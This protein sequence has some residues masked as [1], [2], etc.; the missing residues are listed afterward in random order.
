MQS[1][2]GGLVGCMQ[3]EHYCCKMCWSPKH[4]FCISI[5]FVVDL[6]IAYGNS[7]CFLYAAVLHR[8][9]AS[10]GGNFALFLST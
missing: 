3:V 10:D 5:L 9:I 7:I 6:L 8:V 1:E 4:H 2:L